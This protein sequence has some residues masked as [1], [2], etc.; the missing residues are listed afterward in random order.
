MRFFF[1][2]LLLIIV[3]ACSDVGKN[4][5]FIPNL[6]GAGGEFG[7]TFTGTNC[8]TGSH[9]FA[10]KA[11][12]CIGLQN[13]ALSNGCAQDQRKSAFSKDCVALGFEWMESV[14]CDYYIVAA[15]ST[16]PVPSAG[17]ILDQSSACAGRVEAYNFE[18]VPRRRFDVTFSR[19]YSVDTDIVSGTNYDAK[20]EVKD[21]TNSS[22]LQDYDLQ[23]AVLEVRE[24]ALPRNAL[25]LRVVCN[26]THACPK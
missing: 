5:Q 11:A 12:Y 16:L 18:N 2:S 23:S 4:R 14:R 13:E 3:C 24:L 22:V 1:L 9:S 15:N 7:F 6:E 19:G 25:R 8:V 20:I 10:T 21:T 17:Q 26:K